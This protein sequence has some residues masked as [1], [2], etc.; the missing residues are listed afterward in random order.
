MGNHR[1]SPTDSGGYI[2][3]EGRKE[4]LRYKYSGNDY[5]LYY[6]HVVEPLA[7]R[8][9]QRCFPAWLAPN[10]ITITGLALV[11]VAHLAMAWYCPLLEG[12][13]PSWVY[14]LCAASLATYQLLDASDGKQARRTGSGSALGVML[15]HGCDAVNIVVS[16]ITMAATLQ[17]GA[18]WKSLFLVGISAT[19]FFCAT[20]EEFYAG[21]LDLPGPINGPNEGLLIMYCIHAHAAFAGPGFW[22]EESIVLPGLKNHSVFLLATTVCCTTTIVMANVR[23]LLRLLGRT[24]FLGACRKAAPYFT[25]VGLT[26]AWIILD[27]TSLEQR[28][29]SVLWAYGLIYSLSTTRT[30][31]AH[32]CKAELRLW[33]WPIVPLALVVARSA[34]PQAVP[35]LGAAEAS[36]CAAIVLALLYLHMVVCVAVEMRDVLGISIFRIGALREGELT[37]KVSPADGSG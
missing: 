31:L 24:G 7:E 13:A 25:A 26:L 14:A 12:E 18:T 10:V 33:D 19:V 16:G 22:A 5:S 6:I 4:L 20:L 8:L 30:I 35:W 37:G 1:G 9:M 27:P 3:A 2:D 11:G 21:S 36:Y 15:D 29:R 23:N 32:I 34:F 17:M 28:P